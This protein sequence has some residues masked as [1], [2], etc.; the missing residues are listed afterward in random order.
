MYTKAS[1]NTVKT[2]EIE[3]KSCKFHTLYGR[4]E[5]EHLLSI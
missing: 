3:T 2:L 1:P 5:Y 4:K